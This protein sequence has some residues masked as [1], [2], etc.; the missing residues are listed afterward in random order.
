VV[1]A[2]GGQAGLERD[3]GEAGF[4]DIETGIRFRSIRVILRKRSPRLFFTVKDTRCIASRVL[5][6]LK[7]SDGKIVSFVSSGLLELREWC[8]DWAHVRTERV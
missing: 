1:G 7:P 3:Q 5:L 8:V 4:F 2:D 6:V